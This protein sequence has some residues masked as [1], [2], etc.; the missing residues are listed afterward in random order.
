VQAAALFEDAP[1]QSAPIHI[2][3]LHVVLIVCC[4]YS[5]ALRGQHL[6]NYIDITVVVSAVNTG[7]AKGQTGALMMGYLREIFW[8]SAVHNFRLTSEYIPSKSNTL[9]DAL[10][11]GDFATFSSALLEWKAGRHLNLRSLYHLQVLPPLV[12][13]RP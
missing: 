11:R 12:I 1:I 13:W 5:A 4:L 7:T 10:S 8:L 9:A 6:H 2:H 3:E